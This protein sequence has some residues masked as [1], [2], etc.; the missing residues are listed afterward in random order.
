[1]PAADPRAAAHADAAKARALVGRQPGG[2]PLQR[3]EQHVAQLQHVEREVEHEP[4]GL[5][6]EALAAALAEKDGELGVAVG[7]EDPEQPRRPDRRGVLA[8]VDRELDHLGLAL[9]TP[10]QV[11]LD[12]FLLALRRG[13]AHLVEAAPDLGLVHPARV[14]GGEVAPER[15]QGNLLADDD[16]IRLV[17]IH[18]GIVSSPGP[19]RRSEGSRTLA[20]RASPP[21]P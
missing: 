10:L 20:R 15:S 5:G 7:V 21:R 12:P 6:A 8:V 18:S 4:G 1:L 14:I 9:R 17:A 16:E 19:A 13:D 3:L 11:L 2:V